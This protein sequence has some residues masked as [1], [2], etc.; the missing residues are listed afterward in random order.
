MKER[1]TYK[2]TV[3]IRKTPSTLEKLWVRFFLG[4]P[5][6]N[7]VLIALENDCAESIEANEDDRRRQETTERFAHF[8]TL[9]Q[10]HGLPVEIGKSQ[11]CLY[12]G[13][14]VGSVELQRN[15]PMLEVAND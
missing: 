4:R 13:I 12:A 7:N 9:V 2:V 15:D 3:T 10:D 5:S 8:T 1:H 14:M 6:E 11:A